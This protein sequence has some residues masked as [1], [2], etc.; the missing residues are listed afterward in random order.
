MGEVDVCAAVLSVAQTDVF[1]HNPC[2]AK[3][4]KIQYGYLTVYGDCG[5]EIILN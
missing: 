5:V 1:T 4:A 3:K 2:G